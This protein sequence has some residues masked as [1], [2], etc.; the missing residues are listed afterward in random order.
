MK[1]LQLFSILFT[2][3]IITSCSENSLHS[4]YSEENG[5][6]STT[7]ENQEELTVE[8][9]TQVDLIKDLYTDAFQRNNITGDDIFTKI[10]SGKFDDYN[11][12]FP[13]GQIK[14]AFEN[15]GVLLGEAGFEIDYENTDESIVRLQDL[16]D[17]QLRIISNDLSEPSY[18][19][20]R[21]DDCH[22]VY[23]PACL[24]AV[25][26]AAYLAAVGGGPGGPAA[27][28]EIIADGEQ[29]CACKFCDHADCDE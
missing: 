12:I 18:V 16:S 2:L 13:K 6:S 3:I 17:V 24:S 25:Y 20:S 19:E 5:I 10:K 14:S 8:I 4:T 15:L 28:L 26:A 1:F 27:A 7:S 23:Y 11:S 29:A 9:I 22:E 21:S